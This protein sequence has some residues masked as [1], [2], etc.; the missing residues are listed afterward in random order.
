VSFP[1]LAGG[2]MPSSLHLRH[3]ARCTAGQRA[4]AI[5][6]L[7]GGAGNAA[8]ARWI[9]P[10]ASGRMLQRQE[11]DDEPAAPAPNSSQTWQHPEARKRAAGIEQ[12][13][14]VKA[15]PK[16][17]GLD[18]YMQV[19]PS[20]VRAVKGYSSADG[21]QI[22]LENALLIIAQGTAEH[23]PYDP[24]LANKPVI[25]EGNML[26]GVTSP[27]DATQTT[28]TTTTEFDEQGVRRIEHDRAFRAYGSLDEAALGYLKRWRAS[29]PTRPRIRPS[30][31]CSTRSRHPA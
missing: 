11:T 9:R 17:R 2:G 19:V 20:V 29:I 6:A 1:A 13:A 16:D 3:L 30:A 22:P 4:A 7:S 8:V 15:K 31:G 14:K 5:S 21:K 18:M 26:W 10:A 23:A 12:T 27:S 28:K 24:T 25:P